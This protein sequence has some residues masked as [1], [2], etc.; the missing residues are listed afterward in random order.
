[1]FFV[2]CN[3]IEKIY[4]ALYYIIAAKLPSSYFPL[5][6]FFNSVRIKLVKRFISGVGSNVKVQRGVRFGNGKFISIGSHCEINENVY[7]QRAVIGS[8]VMIAP[9]VAILGASHKFDSIE[10]PMILQGVD[11][12]ISP[13]IEDDV[14]IGRNVVIMPGVKIGKGSIIGAGAVVTKDVNPYSIMG[15]IPAKVIKSRI[16][17]LN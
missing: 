16:R 14:W 10:V 11:K 8:Y 15:G 6:H 5:G 2:L 13:I 4:L 7:I 17:C 9:N 1:M 12:V 3:M